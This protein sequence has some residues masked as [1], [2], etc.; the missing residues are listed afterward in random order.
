VIGVNGTMADFELVWLRQHM[1]GGRWHLARKGE[2]RVYTPL[3][4]RV[5]ELLP[6]RTQTV[7]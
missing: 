1:D 2:L 3:G 5:T 6:S 7:R 4:S